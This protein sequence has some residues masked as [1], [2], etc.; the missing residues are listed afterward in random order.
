V[1]VVTAIR[2]A[3]GSA[4]A[5][6]DDPI[7]LDELQVVPILTAGLARGM[8][9]AALERSLRVFG[10]SL[11]RIAETEADLWQTRT[12]GP[13]AAWDGSVID[14]AEAGETTDLFGPAEQALLGVYHGQQSSA[15]LRNILEGIEKT[16][17][18][19]GLHQPTAHVPAICF[20]DITGYTHLTEESG[21]AA[22]ADLASRLAR[23]VHRLS[24]EH[25]GRTVKSLGDGVMFYFPDPGQGVVAALDMVAGVVAAGLPPAHVGLHAGPV[26]FQ[27]GDY[28]G[29]TVNVAARIADYARQGE[30]LVSNEVV[31]RCESAPV[32]FT[33]IGPVELKGVAGTTELYQATRA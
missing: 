28:F 21:D 27:E 11:R 2:E 20:L 1:E 10:E 18:G 8:R 31:E 32:H 30:V 5:A 24:T 22:A 25:G 6:P 3:M 15:F 12:Q 33:Q 4:A 16:L 9:P 19:A 14:A 17:V 26:L 23:L 7:R 29:R 13:P